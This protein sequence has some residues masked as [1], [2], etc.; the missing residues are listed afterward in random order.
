MSVFPILEMHFLKTSLVEINI[1]A[2]TGMRKEK[3]YK[4]HQNMQ[5]KYV[6][7]NH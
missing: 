6:K 4:H 2:I 1:T 5:E 3:K 7:L